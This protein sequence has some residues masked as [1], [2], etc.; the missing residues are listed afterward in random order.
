MGAMRLHRYEIA[1]ALCETAVSR[2]LRNVRK[3]VQLVPTMYPINETHMLSQITVEKVVSQ[4]ARQNQDA[5]VSLSCHLLPRDH[6]RSS[7]FFR[8]TTSA[9]F[10]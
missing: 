2:S 3:L 4:V 7:S 6:L 5:R 9:S 10:H 1:P 8:S